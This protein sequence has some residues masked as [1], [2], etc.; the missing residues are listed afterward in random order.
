MFKTSRKSASTSLLTTCW[1][2]KRRLKLSRTYHDVVELLMSFNSISLEVNGSSIN[3]QRPSCRPLGSGQWT[4]NLCGWE[5]ICKFPLILF[6]FSETPPVESLLS[7][8]NT[9]EITSFTSPRSATWWTPE[10]MSTLIF[11]WVVLQRQLSDL[12][13]FFLLK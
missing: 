1:R 2:T 9:H 3:L 12:I 11:R 5:W 6:S 8:P 7:S 13:R 10:Q 4:P